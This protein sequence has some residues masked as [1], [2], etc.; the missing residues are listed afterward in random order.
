[1]LPILRLAAD[2]QEH[3]LPRVTEQLAVAFKLSDAERDELLP[4]GRQ[5][6]FD[7]R[8]GW[9]R[10]Y[11]KRPRCSRTC[12]AVAVQQTYTLKKLD[13]DYFTENADG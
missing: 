11:L 10:T 4:S 3:A 13:L 9:A 6:R 7:N 12:G 5:A 8:V 1:M 2:E